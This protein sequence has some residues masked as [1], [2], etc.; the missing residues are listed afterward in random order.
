MW[1]KFKTWMRERRIKRFRARLKEAYP[2]AAKLC[3]RVSWLSEDD[4]MLNAWIHVHDCSVYRQLTPEEKAAIDR[5][6]EG[7]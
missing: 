6:F 4:L 7:D 5:S 2:D 1:K 3:D